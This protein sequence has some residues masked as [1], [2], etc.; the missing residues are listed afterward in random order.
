MDCLSAF[1]SDDVAEVT[2]STDTEKYMAEDELEAYLVCP[3]K[4]KETDI[5]MRWKTRK[6][7]GLSC[8]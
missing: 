4:A 1:F 7:L 8:N 2:G 6:A 3:D 5:L